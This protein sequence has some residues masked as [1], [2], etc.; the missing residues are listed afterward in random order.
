MKRVLC[1]PLQSHKRLTDIKA[2][3]KT[4]DI[5]SLSHLNI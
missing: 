2:T 4:G 1:T 3:I 5:I